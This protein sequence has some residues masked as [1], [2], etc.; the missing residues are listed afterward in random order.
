[1][2]KNILDILNEQ[3]RLREIA[4][5]AKE[6]HKHGTDPE[7]LIPELEYV[8]FVCKHHKY[9]ED[10]CRRLI[11]KIEEMRLQRVMKLHHSH[12]DEGIKYKC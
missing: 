8:G 4:K 11:D 6:T 2:D 7:V 12:Q 5:T 3:K 9:I 10:E 1:M